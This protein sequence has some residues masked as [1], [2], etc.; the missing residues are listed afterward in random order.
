MNRIKEFVYYYGF[1]VGV[2]LVATPAI[3]DILFHGGREWNLISI[4]V[5]GVLCQVIGLALM[6]MGGRDS[7]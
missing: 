7:R 4:G 5:I 1:T 2:A 6:L 3:S